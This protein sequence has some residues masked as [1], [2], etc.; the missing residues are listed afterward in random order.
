MIPG[1][2]SIVM[3]CYNAVKYLDDAINSLRTQTYGNLEILAVNDGSIDDTQAHLERHASSDSRVR[4]FSQ[5]NAGPSAARNTA[6]RQASGEYICFLDADDVFVPDKIERQVRFLA[7]HPDVDLVYS[8][9]Y[10]SDEEL[11]L[12]AL[13]ATRIKYTN[14]V[15][16]FAMRN[17]FPPLVPM[18]RS[19]LLAVVGEFDDSMR[20]AEDWDYWIRCAKVA[21]FAYLPGPMVIYRTHGAQCHNDADRMFMGGKRVLQK[22]FKSD[23]VLYQRALASWYQLNAKGRWNDERYVE[24]AIFLARSAFHYKMAGAAARLIQVQSPGKSKRGGSALQGI[25]TPADASRSNGQ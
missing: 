2:V 14:M 13:S 12:T 23:K 19:K 4:I 1:K 22:H 7:E 15:E 8:D 5:R 21:V 9:Y 24:T 6:L 10:T 25:E 18:F 20:M 17:W 11:N 3:P 16:A